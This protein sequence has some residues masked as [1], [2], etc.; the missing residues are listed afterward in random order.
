[1][2]VMRIIRAFCVILALT[3]VIFDVAIAGTTG[4]ISGVVIDKATQEPLPGVNLVIE[5]TQI[6]TATDIK[7]QYSILNMP[8]GVYTLNVSMM[9]YTGMRIEN[10]RVSIDLTTNQNVAL[11]ET[12]LEA[13]ETVT[14]VAAFGA[15]GHDIVFVERKLARY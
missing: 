3:L 4:K 12:V 15:A 10:I 7:G 8:P 11:E 1:M 2:K 9:G 13:A 5:G 6:G 14:V